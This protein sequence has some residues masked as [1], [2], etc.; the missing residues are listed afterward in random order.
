MTIPLR[1]GTT[2]TFD[3]DPARRYRAWTD[4]SPGSETST[5]HYS[6]DSD[7]PTWTEDTT[8]G[9]EWTRNISGLSGMLGA[10]ADETDETELQLANLHG[11]IIATASTDSQATVPTATFDA[12]EFGQPRPEPSPRYGWHGANQRAVDD[13]SGMTLMGAR[14]YNPN[15]GR[16]LQTD[17]IRGG[18]ANAYDYANADP[19]NQ[20]D[21]SGL[22]ATR[23]QK[24]AFWRAVI[25]KRFW[26]AAIE[27]QVVM[28][29]WA[30]GLGTVPL[31]RGTKLW[32]YNHLRHRGRWT[33]SYDIAIRTTLSTGKRIGPDGGSYVYYTPAVEVCGCHYSKT[34]RA[35][36]SGVYFTV[37]V[38]TAVGMKG[39]ITAYYRRLP[40]WL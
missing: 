29:Y 27:R 17:P 11:D 33:M 25:V 21:P 14:L 2:R 28:N 16:F 32:G 39:I 31:R 4:S 23:A 30:W 10:I 38:E 34:A 6:D 26:A 5:N 19:I 9:N 37:V 36:L 3:L 35:I 8:S 13:H 7:S 1:N 24:R 20:E 12:T 15:T 18:S 40:S 22:A